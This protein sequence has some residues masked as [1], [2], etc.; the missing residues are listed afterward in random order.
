M[1]KPILTPNDLRNLLRYDCQTGGFIWRHRGAPSW[2]AKHAGKPA[3][4]SDQQG[5]KYGRIG[6][7]KIWAHRAAWALECG[8]WPDESGFGV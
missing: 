6:G 4:N 7:Q 3:L 1:I 2:D 5:Y 8:I